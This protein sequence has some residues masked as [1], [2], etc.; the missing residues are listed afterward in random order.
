MQI[1][2]RHKSKRSEATYASLMPIF[3]MRIEAFKL[4][5]TPGLVVMLYTKPWTVKVG[6][7]LLPD[8]ELLEF[9][10]N[11]KEKDQQHMPASASAV[12]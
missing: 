4:V 3:F 9:V 5:Q 10:C 7:T 11:E 6:A 8:T 1:P 12:R 2:N